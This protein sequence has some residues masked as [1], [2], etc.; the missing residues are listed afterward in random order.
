MIHKE[1][2]IILRTVRD[3]FTEEVERL[4]IDSKEQFKKI[5]HFVN[6]LCPNLR[7]KVVF[8][9]GDEDLFE[10][11]QIAQQIEK[12]YHTKV[13]LRSGGYLVIEQTEG[14][15][16]I[17]VNSGKFVSK[18]NLEETVF[19]VNIEAANEVARQ[20]RL[21]DLGGIIIMDFIDMEKEGNRN[22]V[23][24]KFTE[25]LKQDKA[26]S[27]VLPVSEI[28]LIQMTRKRMRG[29]IESKMYDNCPYCKGRGSIKSTLTM[30]ISAIRQMKRMLKSL[31]HRSKISLYAHPDVAWRL[32]NEQRYAISFLE[33]KYK[34]KITINE[35]PKKHIEDLS[36][37]T[38]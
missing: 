22:K 14:L 3:L 29:S 12:L 10:K 38:N 26:R 1:F 33:D 11:S 7:K 37:K 16:A 23:Y 28:G 25:A 6:I 18:K 15:V 17:D 5:L 30:A 8:H 27:N 34:S 9:Q 36:L 13:S 4:V 21:R 20:I 32:L 24:Q 2:D 31:P 19:K 35:D